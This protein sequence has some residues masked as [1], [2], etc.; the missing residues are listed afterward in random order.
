MCMCFVDYV[1]GNWSKN[2]EIKGHCT[3]LCLFPRGE[4]LFGTFFLPGYHTTE[5]IERTHVVDS[6]I[7]GSTRSVFESEI[8]LT[9]VQYSVQYPLS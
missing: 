6:P 9:G 4:T 8:W 5:Y 1:S 7:V 3:G 2:A